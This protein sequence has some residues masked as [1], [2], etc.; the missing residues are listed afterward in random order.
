L[1][2]L[3]KN[4]FNVKSDTRLLNYQGGPIIN[5]HGAEDV[6]RREYKN[7][8]VDKETIDPNLPENYVFG[9]GTDAVA[10]IRE[11]FGL[12]E[13]PFFLYA[14]T[15]EKSVFKWKK[16]N[17]VQHNAYEGLRLS[18]PEIVPLIGKWKV[19][20]QNYVVS[21][22]YQNRQ[23]ATLFLDIA[24][25]DDRK[26]RI[27]IDEQK[28]LW[29]EDERLPLDAPLGRQVKQE[30]ILLFSNTIPTVPGVVED[31][32]DELEE[33]VY[34]ITVKTIEDQVE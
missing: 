15:N 12:G 16:W 3:S 32:D 11:N 8:R 21:A 19:G 10:R 17:R 23:Y 31:N 24:R 27:V 25:I 33:G 2:S 14:V 4:V 30:A 26:E 29:E 13:E 28:R 7:D 9:Q 34:N 20:L 22:N 5:S 1:T 6:W 18:N